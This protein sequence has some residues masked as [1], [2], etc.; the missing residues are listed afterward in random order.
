VRER[1]AEQN[2][3]SVRDAGTDAIEAVLA[4]I[5]RQREAAHERLFARY[6]RRGPQ[7]LIPG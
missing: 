2:L 1:I 6:G 4:D 5:A 7:R 3:A